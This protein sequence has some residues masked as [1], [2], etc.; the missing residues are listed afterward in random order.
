[1]SQTSVRPIFL[2][3]DDSFVS[4]NE[5]HFDHEVKYTRQHIVVCKIHIQRG[6]VQDLPITHMERVGIVI[7]RLMASMRRADPTPAKTPP[8]GW[9]PY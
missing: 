5:G 1:M 7:A 8:Q 6:V 3:D 9:T 4:H 2:I